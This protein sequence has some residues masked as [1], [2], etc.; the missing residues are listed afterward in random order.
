MSYLLTGVEMSCEGGS[1]FP[2]TPVP[3]REG[4][5]N[6]DLQSFANGQAA[7]SR[8]LMGDRTGPDLAT[9]GVTDV[10]TLSHHFWPRFTLTFGLMS[11]IL[12][13]ASMRLVVPAGMRFGFRTR[14]PRAPA[15]ASPGD[16]APAVEETLP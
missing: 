13:L 11:L 8:P 7:T 12:T 3:F 5:I 9:A 14:R 15:S 6:L 4:V 2:S 16:G 10:Q 1:C